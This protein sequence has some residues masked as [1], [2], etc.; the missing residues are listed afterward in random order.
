MWYYFSNW[1]QCVIGIDVIVGTRNFDLD[2]TGTSNGDFYTAM[3]HNNALNRDRHKVL[4]RGNTPNQFTSIQLQPHACTQDGQLAI[5]IKVLVKPGHALWLSWST[6]VIITLFQSPTYFVWIKNVID[7][8]SLC[9]NQ[10]LRWD[11]VMG[12]P[13]TVPSTNWSSARQSLE[14]QESADSSFLV[15]SYYQNSSATKLPFPM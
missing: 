4:L 10:D 9:I 2:G 1:E 3:L 13:L 8:D 5:T 6:S 14:N 12:S 7:K 11:S 15:E